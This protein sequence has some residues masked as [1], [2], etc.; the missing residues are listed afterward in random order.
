MTK[1][2]STDIELGRD[3]PVEIEVTP[4]MIEAGVTVY[5]QLCQTYPDY[6]L[7]KEIYS[8]MAAVQM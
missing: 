6:L 3:R 4:A 2:E 7:V 1:Q 8:A 5:E